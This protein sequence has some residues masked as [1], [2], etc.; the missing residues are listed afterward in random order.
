MA[1]GKPAQPISHMV[2]FVI[3]MRYLLGEPEC[4][5]GP[6]NDSGWSSWRKPDKGLV[7]KKKCPDYGEILPTFRKTH[8]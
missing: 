1:I 4:V 8:L 2:G 3:K 7:K 5:D 6:Q